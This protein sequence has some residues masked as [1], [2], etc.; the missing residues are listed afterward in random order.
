MH[1][2]AARQLQVELG[3]DGVRRGGEAPAVT[4]RRRRKGVVVIGGLAVFCVPQGDCLPG[5][6]G[7]GVT[8]REVLVD[9]LRGR[10]GEGPWRGGTDEEYA[11]GNYMIPSQ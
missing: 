8:G 6:A 10:C 2:M 3:A 1:H 11:V 9:V 5:G 7:R 4:A